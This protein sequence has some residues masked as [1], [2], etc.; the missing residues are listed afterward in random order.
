MNLEE[1]TRRFR[2]MAKDDVEPYLF[3]DE[4]VADWL[5]DAER[6]AAIRGRLLL[7]DY[8]PAVCEIAIVP[9]TASYALHPKLYELASVRFKPDGDTRSEAIQLVS[10]E[11]L[12]DCVRDWREG[13]RYSLDLIRYLAG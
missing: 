13:R 2:V 6:E 1:L 11:W 8:T 3:S 9:G 10:R 4:D 7:D 5:T 12:D